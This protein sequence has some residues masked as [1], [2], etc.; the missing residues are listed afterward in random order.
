[1]AVSLETRVVPIVRLT[2][3]RKESEGYNEESICTGKASIADCT[4]DSENGGLGIG[5]FRWSVETRGASDY[6]GF[7]G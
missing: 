6:T 2:T 4:E 3:D 5:D 7:D 1:M